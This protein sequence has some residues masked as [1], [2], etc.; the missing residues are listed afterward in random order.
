MNILIVDDNQANLEA[1][2]S[3]TGHN[4]VTRNNI[5]WVADCGFCVEEFQDGKPDVLMTD[6]WMPVGGEGSGTMPIGMWIALLAIHHG[7]RT[8]VVYSDVHH[9]KD[10]AH[11]WRWKKEFVDHDGMKLPITPVL[12]TANGCRLFVA[13][14]H[15]G[16]K[17]WANVLARLPL[18]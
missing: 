5:Q 4:V 2:K 1:G 6:N 11:L 7:V 15:G 10:P 12:E 9:H 13:E 3:I 16:I 14:Q 8:V 17:D 18:S